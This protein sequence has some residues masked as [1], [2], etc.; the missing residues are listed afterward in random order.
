M[1][2]IDDRAYYERETLR[3]EAPKETDPAPF[4]E[5]E[6]ERWKI[7]MRKLIDQQKTQRSGKPLVDAKD[8][9]RAAESLKKAGMS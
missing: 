4:D 1:L 8:A 5:A 2:R 9:T 6:H 7:E 3:V